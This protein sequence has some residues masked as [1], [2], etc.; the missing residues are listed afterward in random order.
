[1]IAFVV[2]FL[3]GQIRKVALRLVVAAA[4][5]LSPLGFFLV[6]L[7]NPSASPDLRYAA[8]FGLVMFGFHIGLWTL[9]C[10]LGVLV[11]TAKARGPR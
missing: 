2:G 10:V 1:M 5:A 11:G 9:F 6:P 8:S 3:A 4:M 7:L